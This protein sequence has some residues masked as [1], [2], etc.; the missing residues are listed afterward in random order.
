ME[1]DPQDEAIRQVGYAFTHHIA[2]IGNSDKTLNELFDD[3]KDAITLDSIKEVYDKQNRI[4]PP[5]A[6]TGLP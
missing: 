6:A 3:F 2:R 4:L 5:Q 1:Y